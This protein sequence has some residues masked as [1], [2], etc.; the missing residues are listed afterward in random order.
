MRRGGDRAAAGRALGLITTS[1]QALAG[2]LLP[3]ATVFLLLLCNDRAVL[4]PWVNAPWLNALAAVI[5]GVLVE[6]SLVLVASTAFP[7]VNVTHLFVGL[8]IALAV[9]LR[10]DRGVHAAAPAGARRA[11]G[12]A[13]PRRR[14]DVKGAPPR[15]DDAA[16]GAAGA[17]GVVARSARGDA[18][19]A[20]LP[21]G[22]GGVAGREDRAARAAEGGPPRAPARPYV[23]SVLPFWLSIGVLSATQGALVAFPGKISI[24]W[25]E[26]RGSRLWAA[27]PPLSVILFVFVARAAEHTSAQSL[28]YLALVAVPILAALALGW[29]GHG[30]RPA[31]ALAA[32]ALFALAWADRGGLA[33]QGAALALS[34]LS[35]AALGVLLAAVTPPRWLAAGIVLM[36]CADTAL[37]VSELLQHPNEVLDAAHP[38]AGLPK[39]Q[40]EVFGSAAMGYGDLFVAGLLGGLLARGWPPCARGRSARAQQ[41]RAAALVVASRWRST[42]CSS[43]SMSCPPRCRSPLA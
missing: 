40:A 37:V 9:A 4:G 28:T 19:A 2:V 16:A 42:C 38:P 5:I 34:A 31:L 10:G 7:H 15:V 25:V 17:A 14:G 30:A 20:R 23:E 3:S 33:G 36:A 39:L 13:P 12:P 41:V 26:R 18:A 1:V 8:S 43:P 27:V 21:R 22:R 32:P 11:A 35:C 24:P 6:L 29:W